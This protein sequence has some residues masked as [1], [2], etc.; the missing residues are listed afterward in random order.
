M[1]RI[2]ENETR[3]AHQITHIMP[4]GATR[5]QAGAKETTHKKT[6]AEST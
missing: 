4:A 5:G 6:T 2:A 3:I 1:I